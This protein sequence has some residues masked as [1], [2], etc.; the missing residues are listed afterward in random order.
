MCVSSSGGGAEREGGTES[1]ACSRL[2]A[3]RTEPDAE[4]ELTNH[5]IMTW[6][7][8]GCLTDWATQMPHIWF[9]HV[10]YLLGKTFFQKSFANLH[11][12]LKFGIFYS[13]FSCLSGFQV[14][15]SIVRTIVFYFSIVY[16]MGVSISTTLYFLH[17]SSY[18]VT[19]FY[20]LKL[21][22]QCFWL[23]SPA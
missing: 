9:F 14:Y 4:L 18:S 1:E 17:I 16:F 3:V 20:I 6:A 21:A 13:F 15:F 7:K 2:W 22:S 23:E 5:E 11:L 10:L 12:V 19:T 8:V